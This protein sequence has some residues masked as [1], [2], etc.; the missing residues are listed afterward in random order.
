MNLKLHFL[1]FMAFLMF[2]VSVFA[3]KITGTVTGGGQTVIGGA[4]K[5]SPSGVGTSTGVDGK[6]SLALK[7]GTYQVTF[8]AIGFQPKTIAVQLAAGDSKVLDVDLAVS[9]E[10][11]KEVVVV[12]GRGAPRSKL[13]S[14]VP[15]DVININSINESTAKPDLMSQLNQNVPSFNYNKQSGADGA[16]AIDFASLRGLGYDQTLVL[17]NGIRRHMSAYVDAGQS[18]RGR[19]NS[20]TDLNAIPENAI[21]HVEILRDGASAQ[22]GSD[23]IAGVINIVLK[24]DINHLTFDAG[25]SGY[26]DQKYNTLSYSDPKAYYTGKKFDGQT[27]T[28]GADY[29]IA[30]GKNGGFLNI[31]GNYEDQGKTFR[32]AP[33]LAISRERRAFGDGSI[34][35]GGGMFNMEVPIKGTN[36]TF[37]AFGGYNYKHSQVYAYTRS[38]NYDNGLRANATKFPTD[39]VTGDLIFVPGIMKVDAP[40][41]TPFNADNVYYNPEEDVYIKDES[42]AF[43]FRGKTDDDWQWSVSNNTGR[44]DFH[45]YGENTFN[46]ALIVVPGQ[47]IQTRFNDGGFNYLQNTTNADIT[48]RF[49]G[50]AQGLQLSFGG[51]VRYE[52]Y[53]IYAGEPNSYIGATDPVPVTVDGVTTLEVKASG[54]EGYPGYSPTD[55]RIA[56]RASEGA[57]SEIS[58]DVT[59]K[60]LIDLAERFENYDDFG[61]VGTEKFATRYKLADNFNLRG[62]ISTGF[63]APSLQQM[64]FSNTNTEIVNGNLVYTKTVPNYSPIAR[65]A[66]IPKLTPETST[67][68]SLGFTWAPIPQLNVSVD[69]YDVKIKNRIVFSGQYAEGDP[70]FGDPNT[71]GTLNN[72]LLASQVAQ[73]SFYTNAVNTTNTGVDIVVD[74]KTRWEKQHFN[75]TFAGNI[76]HVAIN[77]IN[78]P[79]TFKGSASDSAIFFSDR[80]Q[81]FLKYA[82]PTAKLNLSLEYGIAKWAFGTRFTYYGTVKELGFGEVAAPANAPDKFFPYVD[83]DNGGGAVP[84]IFVFHPKVTTDIYATLK[85]TK[86]ISWYI[87]V[88]NLFNV[89]PDEAVVK[90]SVSATS[91]TSSFGDSNSGGPFESVQMGFNGMRLFTKFKF[92]F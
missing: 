80:E 82:A 35:L 10:S 20:G 11:L 49:A 38:W 50:V 52:R 33:D 71:P 14:A 88:D 8:S 83:L 18:A 40:D 64:N 77:Q 70:S 3:Q 37:F 19:G 41:G 54:S 85:V 76:Q 7:P 15:V 91:G 86:N 27:L 74:Y 30:V 39:P 57:Y 46:A 53:Q 5:A 62:S 78:V 9:S 66:G 73:A 32:Y 56:D 69:G 65:A 68:Y 79:S 42:A 90:G 21:D 81:Y 59:K 17:V 63:R 25:F 1:L 75:V 61:F 67:N 4:V 51:E 36:T 2:S 48:K 23:A 60:W 84:E 31:G 72:L 58:L 92:S 47:P 24:K 6:Y 28:L 55:A 34:A 29:G 22:Y 45:Y 13:E 87:G 26:D 44:N 43:G 12:G 16:D 89:H